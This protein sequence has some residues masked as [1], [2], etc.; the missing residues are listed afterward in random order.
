MEE[1]RLQPFTVISS[2]DDKFKIW[3]QRPTYNGRIV[4]TCGF[5]LKGRMPFVDAI[6]RLPYVSVEEVNNVDEDMSHLILRM[7][8]NSN[9]VLL[10]EDIQE[11]MEQYIVKY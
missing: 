4:C 9:D 7:E 5:S 8:N 6:D 1:K 10:I 2:P 3:V 11:L